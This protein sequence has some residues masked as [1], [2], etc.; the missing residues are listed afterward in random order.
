MY[1]D[2]PSV[3]LQQLKIDQAFSS[4]NITLAIPDANSSQKGHNQT[5]FDIQ[6]R[7]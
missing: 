2:E 5:D 7:N 4:N 3:N 6:S 1:S